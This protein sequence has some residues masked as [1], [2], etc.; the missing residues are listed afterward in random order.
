MR[1]MLLGAVAFLC[2]AGPAQAGD[3]TF[4]GE[5][6]LFGFNFCPQGWLPADGR[7]M[8]ISQ[9]TALFS[10]LGT[11]YGGDG[12]TTFKLPEPKAEVTKDFIPLTQCIA[13]E[14]IFPSRP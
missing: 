2:V 4:I 11:T 1:K 5:V 10:L 13:V 14:G 9:N 7:L 3:L 8:P 12:K 6:E